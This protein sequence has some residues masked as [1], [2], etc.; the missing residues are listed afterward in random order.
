[1]AVCHSFRAQNTWTAARN[2]RRFS[3]YVGNVEGT[4]GALIEGFLGSP[5]G[6]GH[7]GRSR[8]GPLV[9]SMFQTLMQTLLPE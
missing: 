1:M 8:Q 4:R 5:L 9:P 2:M 6:K 7:W 3:I